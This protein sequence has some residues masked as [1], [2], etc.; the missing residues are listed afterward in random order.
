MNE[1]KILAKQVYSIGNY[2]IVPIRY[3]DR[4]NIMNWR[5]EQMYHLRQAA[6]LTI[7]QQT[8]YFENVVQKLFT[9]KNP[10]QILF[11]Y[12]K[13]DKCIGY[14]GLVHINCE[15]KNAEMSFLVDTKILGNDILY[16]DCFQTYLNLIKLV[17]FGELEFNKLYTET[18]DLRDNHIKILEEN[19]FILEGRLREHISIDGTYYDSLYHSILKKEYLLNK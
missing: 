13:D 1:Y 5:N 17:A 14:G 18:Y 16:S 12:L 9:E 15:D 6:P 2:S 11:S 7:E 4:L 19:N 10:Y 8:N 3:K